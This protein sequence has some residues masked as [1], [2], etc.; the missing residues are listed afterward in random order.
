MKKGDMFCSKIAIHKTVYGN[1]TYYIRLDK[2][3]RDLELHKLTLNHEKKKQKS[4]SI[5]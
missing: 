5:I 4:Q 3:M 2:K 1:W